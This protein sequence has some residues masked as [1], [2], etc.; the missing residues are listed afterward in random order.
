MPPILVD[1]NWYAAYWYGAL[2]EKP[3]RPAS[4]LSWVALTASVLLAV[5]VLRA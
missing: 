1:P 4:A 5:A 3:S 2:P